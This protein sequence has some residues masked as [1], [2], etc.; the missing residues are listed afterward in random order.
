MLSSS[1][2]LA[3]QPVVAAAHIL[4]PDIARPPDQARHLYMVLV[5]ETP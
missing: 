1:L 2:L 3:R 4:H 5:K